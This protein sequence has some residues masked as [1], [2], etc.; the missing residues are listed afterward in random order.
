MKK[1]TLGFKLVVGGIMAVLIPLLVVGLFAVIK[2]SGALETTAKERAVGGATKLADLVQEVLTVEMKVAGEIAV[3]S[4]AQNAAT[5]VNVEAMGKSLT[6]AMTKIGKDYEAILIT[7]VNGL[8]VVDGNNGGY[9]GVSLADREYFKTAK[10]GKANV[11]NVVKSKKTGL[12]VASI[13]VPIT[14]DGTFVGSAVIALKIDYIA[15]KVTAKM[16][17]TGYGFMADHTGICIAHPDK[18][19]ILTLN[20]STTKGMEEITKKILARYWRSKRGFKTMSL[21]GHKRLPD[22]LR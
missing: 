22:L 20:F 11:G 4:D 13:C 18:T 21:T 15:D 19:K 9:K 2:A 14:K 3:S 5:G 8:V 10:D 17:K 1:R 6:D 16:G 12:P 7:D